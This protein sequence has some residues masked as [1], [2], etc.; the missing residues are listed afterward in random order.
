MPYIAVVGDTAELYSKWSD[1]QAKWQANLR[2]EDFAITGSLLPSSW[3]RVTVTL[4]NTEAKDLE[5]VTVL[6]GESQVIY[7]GIRK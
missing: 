6:I 5:Y 4:A 7:S 2:R 3:T 1:A